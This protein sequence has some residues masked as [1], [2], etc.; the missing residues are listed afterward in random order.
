MARHNI[1][2]SAGCEIMPALYDRARD[3][4][5]ASKK[6]YD[7]FLGTDLDLLLRSHRINTLLITG[8]NTNSCILATVA[9]AN[10]RDYA[11]GAALRAEFA[12]PEPA[13]P[14][15]ALDG[16][17][18]PKEP[19]LGV[20]VEGEAR[21]Y[22]VERARE[23][24]IVHDTVGDVAIVLLSEGAGT[25]IRAYRSGALEVTALDA[26]S[27]DLIAI[28]DDGGDG[29]RWFVQEGALVNTTNGR[30]YEALPRSELYW[31]AWAQTHPATSIWGQ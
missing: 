5:V 2:G 27:V 20:T 10:V 22:P 4:V 7:C 13:F 9:A 1:E 8:V 30:R 15:S 6:R 12:S 19:V 21:A 24:G 31:F 14:T 23:R 25:A 18:T 3:W 29:T 26:S 11:P 16:R 28:G 17:L